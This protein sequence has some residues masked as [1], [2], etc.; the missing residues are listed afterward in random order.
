VPRERATIVLALDVSTSMAA[1][2]VNPTRFRAAQRAA[3]DFVDGVP[4][5]FR[6]GLVAFS[7]TARLAVS[8]TR[9]HE[10]V[11]RAI[12]NLDLSDQT[13]IGEAI[14][15]SLDAL[16][17][18]PRERGRRPEA[19][20]V[21]LSDGDTNTGRPNASAADA[22]ATRGVPVSTIAFGTEDGTVTVQGETIPVTV[23]RDAL[24]EISERTEGRFF[25]ARSAEQLSAVYSDLGTAI[26]SRTEQRE[27]TTWF[28]GAGL[29][30]G[31]AASAGSLVWMSR[32]P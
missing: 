24:R 21:V 2:D 25:E 11:E 18:V 15:A 22:A 20:V 29:V 17:D 27:V 3:T 12:A 5:R 4:T 8:P 31:L 7:G 1:R 26:S 13:A 32:L 6:V 30:L 16:E 10:R 23:N 14:F 28:V 19:R 9:D